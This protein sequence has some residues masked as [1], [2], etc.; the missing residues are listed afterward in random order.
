M[1]HI[2]VKALMDLGNLAFRHVF[3][4]LE[5]MAWDDLLDYVALQHRALNWMRSLGALRVVVIYPS[6]R[7]M[8]LLRLC[9]DWILCPSSGQSSCH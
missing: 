9:L 5:V 6:N 3:S 1:S 8:V 2:S 4:P 7:Y